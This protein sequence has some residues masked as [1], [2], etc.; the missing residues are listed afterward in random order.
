MPP[1]KETTITLPSAKEIVEEQAGRN[2]QAAREL[3]REI[4]RELTIPAVRKSL[5]QGDY[6]VVNYSKKWVVAV[7]VL[8]QELEDP[9]LGYS[10]TGYETPY[11][12]SNA[13][14]Y[15]KIRISTE[16]LPLAFRPKPPSHSKDPF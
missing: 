15:L 4:Q 13:A 11:P 5:A 14:G 12:G 8:I 9:D 7:P 6:C 2:S 1:D 10:V 3:R 16:N